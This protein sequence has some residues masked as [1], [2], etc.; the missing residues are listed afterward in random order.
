MLTREVRVKLLPL[1]RDN[2]DHPNDKRF[3]ER[4]ETLTA[5]SVF[6][7]LGRAGLAIALQ[8]VR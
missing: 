6:D 4:I 2:D 8:V 3:S 5:D 1:L 7:G